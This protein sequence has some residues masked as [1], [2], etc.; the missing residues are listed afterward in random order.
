VGTSTPDDVAGAV[1]R[2]IEGNKGEVDVAPLGMRAGTKFAGIAP[3]LAACVT[4]VTGGERIS[5][6]LAQGQTPKR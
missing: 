2:A 1:L 4:R 3:E 5:S 6:D